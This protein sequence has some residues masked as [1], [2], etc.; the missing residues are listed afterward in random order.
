MT[1]NIPFRELRQYLQ[2]L[3]FTE[4]VQPTHFRFDHSP[5]GSILILRP[6]LPGQTV[7]EFD[8]AVVRKTLVER[9]VVEEAALEHFLEKAAVTGQD[10]LDFLYRV[11]FAVCELG[12]AVKGIRVRSAR[13]PWL[14]ED[15]GF[16]FMGALDDLM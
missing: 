13:S 16:H 5:S 12:G 2:D 10:T 8:L 1:R 4:L 15:Q 11:F 14:P 3:G 6:Y 7:S 9:G